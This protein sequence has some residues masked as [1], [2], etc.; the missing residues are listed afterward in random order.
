MHL[1]PISAAS[2][3]SRGIVI[4]LLGRSLVLRISDPL[5]TGLDFPE[6]SRLLLHKPILRH[7]RRPATDI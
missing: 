1:V 5:C 2:S 7:H 6:V 3:S 4:A